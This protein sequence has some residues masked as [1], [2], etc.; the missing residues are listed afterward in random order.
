MFAHCDLLCAN[1]IVLPP[2][3]SSRPGTND[4]VKTVHF[5]DYE[6]A[7][8]SPAA[9]DLANHFSEWAGY[10]CDYSKVPTRSA[11][12][13]FLS[14]YIQSYRYHQ[15]IPDSEQE[16]MVDKLFEDVDRFHGIP[17]LYWHGSPTYGF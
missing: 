11:R 4:E 1:V 8:P 5:I 17:G 3:E 9:F 13:E 16:P 14:E 10:D 6:Y 12:R 2:S 7:N 15:G